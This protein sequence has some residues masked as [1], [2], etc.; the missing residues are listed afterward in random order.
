MPATVHVDA[1]PPT[2]VV[3]D[4][5]KV[6]EV[7]APPAGVSADDAR[8]AR[9]G[10]DGGVMFMILFFTVA[11]GSFGGTVLATPFVFGASTV[12]LDTLLKFLVAGGVAGLLFG[13][14][15]CRT[16]VQN[17]RAMARSAAPP[18]LKS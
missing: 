13:V 3:V 12:H 10:P 7:A 14:Y 18:T 1:A 2:E 11:A 4:A 15:A 5:A 8:A 6:A 9:S 17:L 16:Y